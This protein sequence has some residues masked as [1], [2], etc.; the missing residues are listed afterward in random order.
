MV[1]G[2]KNKVNYSNILYAIKVVK[3]NKN[4]I[5]HLA[6]TEGSFITIDSIV[7]HTIYHQDNNTNICLLFIIVNIK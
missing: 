4:K 3:Q 7:A 1:V 6:N 5:T 2:L